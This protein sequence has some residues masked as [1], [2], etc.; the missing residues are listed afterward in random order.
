MAAYI[1]RLGLKIT[2]FLEETILLE[3]SVVSVR[4]LQIAWSWN[5]LDGLWVQ[6]NSNHIAPTVLLALRERKLIRDTL[7]RVG[8]C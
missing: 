6:L 2:S 4:C 3:A 1:I 5:I 8:S 7:H